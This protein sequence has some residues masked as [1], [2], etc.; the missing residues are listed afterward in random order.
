M[1]K[2]A[3][4]TETEDTAKANNAADIQKQAAVVP[5]PQVKERKARK[6]NEKFHHTGGR[7]TDQKSQ[8]GCFFKGFARYMQS[9]SMPYI[10]NQEPYRILRFRSCPS[11][12]L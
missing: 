5:K 12:M 2:Q 3:E 6:A 1:E 11:V 8:T 4:Q 10:G 9:V 7:H